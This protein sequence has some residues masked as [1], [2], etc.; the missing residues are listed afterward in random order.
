M[1]KNDEP[2]PR[3]RL[4]LTWSVVSGGGIAT[5]IASGRVQDHTAIWALVV[6][7]AVG[8]CC[9]TAKAVSRRRRSGR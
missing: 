9:E 8:Q 2:D 1:A 7:G 4:S 5:A 6:L 3:L